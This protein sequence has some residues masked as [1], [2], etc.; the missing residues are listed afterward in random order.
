MTETE[1]RIEH[2]FRLRPYTALSVAEGLTI[3]GTLG[4]QHGKI[5]IEY[6][7]EGQLDHIGWP[8]PCSVISR[9]QHLWRKT[10]FEFFLGIPGDPAYW[11]VNLDPNGCWNVYHFT[12]YRQG[13]RE[14]EAADRPFCAA[15][16]DTT[17]FSLSGW[18]D[19][20][21]FVVDKAGLE[22]AV[23][24]VILDRAGVA[25]YWAIDH[26]GKGPDFHNRRSFLVDLPGRSQ[27]NR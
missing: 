10:C 12:G 27:E 24:A 22:V 26:L 19:I 25:G 18:I 17:M 16:M 1:E 6:R 20:H 23:A 14:E 8:A 21:R 13:M 5:L 11:E 4:R 9:C 2:P 15:V 3:S 7:V